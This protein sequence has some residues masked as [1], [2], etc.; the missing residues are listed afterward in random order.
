VS[1]VQASIASLNQNCD[2]RLAIL[3]A[4]QKRQADK[5]QRWKEINMKKAR[6]G[7]ERTMAFGNIRNTLD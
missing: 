7:N 1:Q 4:E 2:K 3:E 6:L 5:A